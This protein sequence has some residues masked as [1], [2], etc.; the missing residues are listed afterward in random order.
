MSQQREHCM[1]RFSSQMELC[2]AQVGSATV[3]EMASGARSGLK[4]MKEVKLL[5]EI[6]GLNGQR[7]PFG[8]ETR[9]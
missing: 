4:Q 3:V 6:V 7:S 8:F 5:A 9:S 2:I 1:E